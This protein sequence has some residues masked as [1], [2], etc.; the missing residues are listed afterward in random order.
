MRDP[1]KDDAVGVDSKAPE[2]FILVCYRKC[3]LDN[4]TAKAVCNKKYGSL[5]IFL[6]INVILASVAAENNGNCGIG[7]PPVARVDHLGDFLPARARLRLMP[8]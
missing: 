2:D 7:S 4:D 6:S 8:L 3:L 5:I 1:K